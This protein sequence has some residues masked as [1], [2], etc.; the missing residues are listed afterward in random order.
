ME[1][2]I[3][4]LNELATICDQIEKL[5]IDLKS[6][7]IIFELSKVE[8]EKVFDIVQ[9][10]YNRKMSAPKDTFTIAIGSIDI[11]FNTSSV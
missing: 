11:I 5:N 9:T 3:E 1:K 4:I 7:T 2:K 10:K 8:F 6:K